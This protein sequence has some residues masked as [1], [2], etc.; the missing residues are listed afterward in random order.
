GLLVQETGGDGDLDMDSDDEAL[1]DASGWKLLHADVFRTPEY[2]YLL[3][4]LVGSGMQLLLMALGLVF[5]SALGVLNPSFRGG[6]ISVGVGLFV[7][8]GLF[9]GYFS[10]RVFKM[11]DGKRWRSNALV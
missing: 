3:A 8:N 5:L 2:G 7:F 6:F 9:S 11:F 10:A 1:E 4:P